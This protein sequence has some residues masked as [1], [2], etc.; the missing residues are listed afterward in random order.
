MFSGWFVKIHAGRRERQY[1]SAVH[2]L[3][4]SYS[5]ISLSKNKRI[6]PL[7]TV[8]TGFGNSGSSS[9]RRWIPWR[10]QSQRVCKSAMLKSRGNL[11]ATWV[12]TIEKSQTK[13]AKRFECRAHLYVDVRQRII[14][15]SWRRIKISVA[16]H[17][18]LGLPSQTLPDGYAPRPP[19]KT[20]RTASNPRASM[21]YRLRQALWGV[22]DRQNRR[23]PRTMN[24][25]LGRRDRSV[26]PMKKI[27]QRNLVRLVRCLQVTYWVLRI[28]LLVILHPF[29]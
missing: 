5:S 18:N 21:S 22:C 7:E 28:V 12:T 8:I 9:I 27:K 3:R 20:I 1:L 15:S 29:K 4:F 24:H 16:R 11:S 26:M 25:G 2:G 17:K 19:W 14:F 13:R 6:L 10:V 23:R